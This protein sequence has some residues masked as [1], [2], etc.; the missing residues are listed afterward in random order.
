MTEKKKKTRGWSKSWTEQVYTSRKKPSPF[1]PKKKEKEETTEK[2]KRATKE[3][4]FAKLLTT[5]FAA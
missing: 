2:K 5:D 3:E 1:K 4:V